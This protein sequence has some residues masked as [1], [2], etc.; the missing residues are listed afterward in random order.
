MSKKYATYIFSHL[1]TTMGERAYAYKLASFLNNPKFVDIP[2]LFSGGYEKWAQLNWDLI[3]QGYEPIMGAESFFFPKNGRPL[4]L[5]WDFGIAA[6]LSTDLFRSHSVVT[7]AY[8]HH[9]NQILQTRL[10]DYSQLI[11]TESLLASELLF[12][13]GYEN[14]LY[15]PH[16]YTHVPKSCRAYLRALA[17]RLR[18]PLPSNAPVIGCISRLD[19]WK[20]L[21]YVI[22]VLHQLE[23]DH[24]F[25]FVLKGDRPSHPTYLEYENELVEKLE[26]LN[27]RPWFF[28]DRTWTPYPHIV[29]IFP[30]FD[31]CVQLSG[32]E[33]ASNTI[34]ELL[35]AG[36]PTLALRASTNP[37]LFEGAVRWVEAEPNLVAAQLPFAV[38]QLESIKENILAFFDASERKGYALR[39]KKLALLRFHPQ[40]LKQRL[41]WI[42]KGL[43][44]PY[45]FSARYKQDKEAYKL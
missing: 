34:V 14:V 11:V 15:L 25:I 4:I 17:K 1:K 36:I 22:E 40:N 43:D 32:A 19:Y 45:F 28:W 9:P 44:S 10:H 42:E 29:N 5:S 20:N 12:K 24:S 2:T 3:E 30:S 41:S 6:M 37:Y 38:P 35:A 21:P 13:K 27:A 33:G 7:K 31:F 16:A 26:N 18:K 8:A 39:A 23:K